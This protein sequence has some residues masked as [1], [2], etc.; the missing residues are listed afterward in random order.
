[1]SAAREKVN[2]YGWENAVSAFFADL[3]FAA[4]Q[5]AKHRAF[6]LTATLTLALG[7]G[8]NAAIF[9]AI[10]SILLAPL[11]YNHPDRLTVL[12]SHYSNNRFAIQRV[13]GPDGMDMREQAKSLQAVSLMAG[14]EEGVQLRD[15]AT[16]TEVT[17]VDED[18]AR[19]FSLQPIAGRLFADAE[20]HRAALVNEQFARNN[21]GSAQAALGQTLHIESEAV[22]IVGILPGTFHYP[23]KTEVWEAFS[24]LPES[25]S[26]TAFNYRAVALLRNDV[27]FQTAQVELDGLSQR[28][29]VA[30]PKDNRN[31]QMVAIPLSE[32]LTGK[33]RPTLMLL[34]GT[35]GHHPAHRVRQRNA[36]ATGA[37][38][39]AAA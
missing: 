8:A 19:V 3:R 17:W 14:G 36:S 37:L 32:A 20:S 4:R 10:D 29:Q 21:F 5:L 27:S 2:S 33:A 1:M 11:P 12:Q 18:F 7:I 34:W 26:R 24:L 23:G 30:Y 35:V 16:Y 39:G 25:K 9:T 15:H 38:H 6:T 13:T 28:L 22:E 31:K